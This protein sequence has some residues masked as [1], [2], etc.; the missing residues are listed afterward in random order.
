MVF[1]PKDHHAQLWWKEDTER[2]EV[3]ASSD[4]SNYD[5][6]NGVNSADG[7][8]PANQWSHIAHTREGEDF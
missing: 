6:L 2:I 7:S 8:V 5:I 1:G 4:G 3:F